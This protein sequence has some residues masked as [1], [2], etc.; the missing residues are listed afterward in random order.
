VGV[1]LEQA[2]DI[3]A[4]YEEIR[5]RFLASDHRVAA[6]ELLIEPMDDLE[7][8]AWP[9]KA[10]GILR[11]ARK[12]LHFELPLHSMLRTPSSRNI[13]VKI[14]A[15]LFIYTSNRMRR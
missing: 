9:A 4:A 11:V 1:S 15:E 3:K 7:I 10:N 5:D 6:V 8:G 12:S 2:R 13:Y 14:L